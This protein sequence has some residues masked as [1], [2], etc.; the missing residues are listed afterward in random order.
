[1]RWWFNIISIS[2][3]AS[4]SSTS[5][6]LVTSGRCWPGAADEEW[7]SLK[8]CS[9]TVAILHSSGE[10]QYRGELLYFLL[11]QKWLANSFSC[12]S[13]VKHC[14]EMVQ[15]FQD[16]FS[17]SI[18]KAFSGQEHGQKLLV[19]EWPEVPDLHQ[20]TALHTFM[21]VLHCVKPWY[22]TQVTWLIMSDHSMYSFTWQG[23]GCLLHCNGLTHLRMYYTRTH[24]HAH[25]QFEL[26]VKQ[27]RELF[28]ILA[29]KHGTIKT[30]SF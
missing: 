24:M 19:C 15:M 8:R 11:Q 29:V 12:N 5:G 3:V 6:C 22:I 18:S 21:S 23:F 30:Y 28:H 2:G 14:A 7:H 20:L 26:N 17:H 1:M 27:I 16:C 4:Q 13:M 10:A 25:T 9:S